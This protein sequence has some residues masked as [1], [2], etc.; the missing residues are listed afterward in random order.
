MR[1]VRRH[2]RVCHVAEHAIVIANLEFLREPVEAKFRRLVPDS[3]VPFNQFA[4]LVIRHFSP[5]YFYAH[6][7]DSFAW[8]RCA[9]PSVLCIPRGLRFP[10]ALSSTSLGASA[11]QGFGRLRLAL[12]HRFSRSNLR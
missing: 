2:S 8:L 6:L 4:D 11:H 12:A 3:L 9:P 10:P 5:I 1:I 7:A